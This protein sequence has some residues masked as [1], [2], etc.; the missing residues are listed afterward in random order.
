MTPGVDRS[1]VPHPGPVP[2]VRFPAVGTVRLSNGLVMRMVEHQGPPLVT[3]L[4]AIPAGS[5]S[6]PPGQAGLAALTADLL[7]EGSLRDEIRIVDG[8]LANAPTYA[9]EGHRPCGWVMLE[10]SC[11]GGRRN[12]A[13]FFS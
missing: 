3:F 9:H 2:S 10:V 7:D 5:A 8:A 12:A 6:D 13:L 1:R 11:Y 4:L